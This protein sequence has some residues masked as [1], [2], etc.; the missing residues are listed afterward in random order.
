MRSRNT[1]RM[2]R[3]Q[4][5]TQYG[6]IFSH[7]DELAWAAAA[8]Y[9]ATG[10]PVYQTQLFQWYDPSD[11]AT[12]R[13]SWWRMYAG[14]GCAARTYAFAASS[15]RLNSS[16]LDPTYL[17][18]CNTQIEEAGTD[19]LTR[20][21]DSAYGTA[22]DLQS[23]RSRTAGWYFGLDRSFDMAV[24]YQVS[25]NA[26]YID[27]ILTNMNYEGGC[28]PLNV[29]Y[30]TGIGYKRQREIVNQYSQND[31]RDM[32]PSGLPLGNLQTALSVS[33]DLWGIAG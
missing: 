21:S 32:P 24:A 28:N 14:Y 12:L 5:L 8:M 4:K 17:A 2:E 10:N 31:G 6:D 19:A 16:Q 7:N 9:V 3:N 15:G 20:S 1:E 13:W 22:F 33:I 27:A 25:P 29:S 23:K 18:E 26:A 11:P 30:I